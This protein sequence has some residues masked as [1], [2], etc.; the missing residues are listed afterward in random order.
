MFTLK[1]LQRFVAFLLSFSYVSQI[2]AQSLVDKGPV[3]E[4]RSGG[5][6]DMLQ[7]TRNKEAIGEYSAG[8]YPGAIMIPINLWGAA[9]STGLFSVPKNTTLTQLLSYAK[10]PTD[11][12]KLASVQIKRVSENKEK[13]FTVDVEDIIENPTTRDFVLMP[14]DIVYLEPKK[15]IIDSRWIVVAGFVATLLSAT[16]AGVL[17]YDRSRNRD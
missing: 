17:I 16:L 3:S 7:N 13:T 4:Q 15:G 1:G 9:K 2:C 6:Y 12:A 5:K 14:N 11:D 10:G 8:Y